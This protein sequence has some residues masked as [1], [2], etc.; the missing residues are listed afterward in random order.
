MPGGHDQ[1]AVECT[2]LL[3][4]LSKSPMRDV[5]AG[6]I[7]HVIC[8][9]M[10]LRGKRKQVWLIGGYRCDGIEEQVHRCVE[11]ASLGLVLSGH[12]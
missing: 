10:Q 6:G 8:P 7:E 9:H 3:A 4:G 1:Q 11:N 12:Q 5:I 2:S